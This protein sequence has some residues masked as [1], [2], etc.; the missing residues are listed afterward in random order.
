MEPRNQRKGALLGPG[1]IL[2]GAL[3]VA[4]GVGVLPAGLFEREGHSNGL[5]I[6]HHHMRASLN[7]GS[8]EE[9]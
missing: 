6:L 7:A 8:P 4:V 2:G 1:L 9:G 3:G 5:P